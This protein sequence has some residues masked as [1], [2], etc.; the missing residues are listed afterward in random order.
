M[1][2]TAITDPLAAGLVKDYAHPGPNVTGVSNQ[3]PMDKHLD[4]ICR[5]LPGLKK[6]GVMYN[7]GEV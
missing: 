1:L 7:A 4:M 3:M 6:L 5:F 2:F